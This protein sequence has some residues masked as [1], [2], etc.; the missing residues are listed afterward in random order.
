MIRKSLIAKEIKKK[1]LIN[2]F[3]LFRNSLS[4]LKKKTNNFN[5]Y[6]NILKK[7]SKLPR[8]SMKIRLKNRCSITGRSR[9]YYNFFGLSRH[10]IREH[11]FNTL[12]PGLRKSSW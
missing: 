10:I 12:I 3:F 11:S 5:D 8:N 6:F 2:K 9:G 4:N 1:F 7:L